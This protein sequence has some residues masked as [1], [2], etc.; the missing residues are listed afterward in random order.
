[1]AGS[2]GAVMP[3]EF[4]RLPESGIFVISASG[5]VNAQET[6][7]AMQGLAG[8]IDGAGT[9][10]LVTDVSDAELELS[11]TDTYQSARRKSQLLGFAELVQALVARQD[12]RPFSVFW[13]DTNVNSGIR[14][15]VFSDRDAAVNWLEEQQAADVA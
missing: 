13:E 15:K 1:V 6:A 9:V 14:T 8:M 10:Y 11:I 5:S 2:E 3:Y 12:Q 4:N 7:T